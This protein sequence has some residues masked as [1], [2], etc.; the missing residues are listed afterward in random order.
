MRIR[1][2]VLPLAVALASSAAGAAA[3]TA[4]GEVVNL[5]DGLAVGRHVRVVYRADGISGQ[6]AEKVTLLGSPAPKAGGSSSEER[7]SMAR[8]RSMGPASAGTRRFSMR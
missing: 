1:I 4:P 8:L 6:T 7:T 2:A 3:Y 5:P